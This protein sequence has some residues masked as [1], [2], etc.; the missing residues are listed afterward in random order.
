VGW[1]S[2]PS[3]KDIPIILLYLSPQIIRIACRQKPRFAEITLGHAFGDGTAQTVHKE[4]PLIIV[5][6]VFLFFD[7]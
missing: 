5:F 6:T 1:S 4:T 3:G 2:G 7:T